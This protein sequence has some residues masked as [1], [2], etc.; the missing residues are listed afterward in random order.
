MPP[1]QA[2]VPGTTTV[3][4]EGTGHFDWIHPGTQA[5]QRLL[6]TLEDIFQK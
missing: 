5:Y 3:M 2:L 6:S 4:L 1:E